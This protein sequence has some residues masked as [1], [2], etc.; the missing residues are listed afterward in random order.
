MVTATWKHLI[1]RAEDMM[2]LQDQRKS[3]EGYAFVLLAF[4]SLS[5]WRNSA[6]FLEKKG[7]GVE[8]YHK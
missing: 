5:S 8:M 6:S 4:S 7:A 3:Y 1:K 2:K